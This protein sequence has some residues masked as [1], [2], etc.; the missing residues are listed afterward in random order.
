MEGPDPM[1][2]RTT[3]LLTDDT[4]TSTVE[5][6]ILT[7]CVAAFAALMFTVLTG[8]DVLAALQGL[9]MRALSVSF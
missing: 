2:P 5:Y 7:V 1:F 8:D 9:I 4:G 6:A 3:H